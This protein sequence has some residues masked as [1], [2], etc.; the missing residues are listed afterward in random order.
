MKFWD[1]IKNA[2]KNALTSGSSP[3]ELALAFAVGIYVAFFPLPATHTVIIFLIYW[4]TGLNFPILFITASI[5]NPWTAV[6]FYS[7][8]YFFG[9]WVVH[10]LL[11]L[12]PAWSISL[13]KLLG[14]GKI[15]LWSFIIGG[16]LLGVSLALF[17]YPVMYR[18]FKKLAKQN[19]S[20]EVRL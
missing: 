1:K 15:C 3:H 4:L 20:S 7:M 6:P 13:E 9:Y 11:G 14:S 5:N 12:S 17:F 2:F 10:D 8:D 16:N 19:S 18:V